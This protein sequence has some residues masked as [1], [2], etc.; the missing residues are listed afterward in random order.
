MN[1]IRDPE[2]VE[3][4]YLIQ[5]G[6]F[7]GKNILEI[8]CGDGWLT[9]RFARGVNNIVGVDPSLTDLHEVKEG[10]PVSEMN[11]SIA[12]AMGEVLP[13][14]SGRFDSALFTSSL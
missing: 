1:W 6:Q 9:R 4:K 13:F 5:A 11:V 12:Q 7:G 3:A 10:Q 8:G 2:E 14:P